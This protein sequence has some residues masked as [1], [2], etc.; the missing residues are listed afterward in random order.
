VVPL[1]IY[2]VVLLVL[3]ALRG[4]L[5]LFWSVVAFIAATTA[6]MLLGFHPPLPAS[7]WK[8]YVAVM[9]IAVLL[10]VSSSNSGWREF[11]RPIVALSG[12]QWAAARWGLIL[13][14]SALVAW[15]TYQGSLPS[16]VPPPRIRSVH[17]SPPNTIT[18]QPPGQEKPHTIDLIRDGNPLRH[19]ENEDKP[20]FAEH[21]TKGREVYYQNCYYCHGDYM[22]ADGHYA[23]AV[24]PPP[25]NFQDPGTI[26]MLQEAY[27]Y[28]RISKGGPGLPD[29]G[30]PW[31]SSMPVWEKMLSEEDMWNVILYL[32]D[33][34]GYRPRTQEG[35]H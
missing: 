5:G 22:A 26:A 9:L 8:Q 35:G 30:T 7:V 18:T 20:K 15:S 16:A 27:L 1:I 33:Y 2:L 12:D 32:Y 23:D 11:F 14:A 4:A 29:T 34:V 25:A 21:V 17:P 3:F 28:W 6:Y 13:V 10:Y 19:L 24:K 31:D